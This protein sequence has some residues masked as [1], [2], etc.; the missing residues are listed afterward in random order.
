MT[1]KFCIH[2][3]RFSAYLPNGGQVEILGENKCHCMKVLVRERKGHTDRRVASTRTH[4]SPVIG[5]GLT[6]GGTSKQ[7]YPSPWDRVQH[8]WDRV[9][10]AWGWGNPP[11]RTWDQWKYYGMEM[12]ATLEKT[13]DQWKYYGCG[14]IDT[15]ENSTIPILRMLAVKMNGGACLIWASCFTSGQVKDQLTRLNG[16]VEVNL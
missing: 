10:L 6:Q 12:G 1:S 2:A 4:P 8:K 5:G 13:W 16:Q 7:R 11:E 14:Q 3:S 15:R 9:P